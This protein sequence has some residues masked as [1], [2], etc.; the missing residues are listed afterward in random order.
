IFVGLSD[1]L[2]NQNAFSGELQHLFK[3]NPVSITSGFGYFAINATDKLTLQF[4]FTPIGGELVTT[5]TSTNENV[6]HTNLYAY[7]YLNVLP[8]VTFTLGLSGDIF[9]TKSQGSE[10]RSQVNPKFGITWNPVPNTT[11]RVAA[12]RTL[13]RTLITDQT[14]EPT[15]V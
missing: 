13:K 4:D 5:S 12:F 14:L 8:N 7:S 10:S 6:R 11:L 3:S 15:Q 1:R 9:T 2:P